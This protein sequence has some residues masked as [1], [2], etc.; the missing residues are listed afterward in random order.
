MLSL[1]ADVDVDLLVLAAAD[2]RRARTAAAYRAALAL[3]R[4][5]LLPENRY[6]DW[7][8]AR[9][10]EL[11]AI[12][13]ELAEESAAVDDGSAFVLP[14][15]TSSFVGR[16][17]ELTEL[18]ALLQRTRL[19]SLCGTG[20]V[21]KT[22][23]ALQFARSAKSRYES[24]AALVELANVDDARL[25]PDAVASALD[26][27]PLAAQSALD[28]VTSFLTPRSVLLVIDNCEHVLGASAA[29]AAALPRGA[30]HLTILATSRE[31][32]H[33]AGEVVFRVPSLDIP[34]PE[35]PLEPGRLLDYE[36]V[37]L[38]VERAAAADPGFT[39]ASDNAVEVVRICL[40]LDGL[41]LALE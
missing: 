3:Y 23:L 30:P 10:D 15:E 34:D 29:L 39:L 12:A 4:G 21:R 7:A 8:D 33:V 1:A 41:P 27:R 31:P 5:E 40:R 13:A 19:L 16:G 25:V 24:G 9:R 32:L 22:R 2:A 37:S 20:G 11:A 17:R 36:A 14:T 38:F 35:Q 6:D 26:V 18:N 28:A